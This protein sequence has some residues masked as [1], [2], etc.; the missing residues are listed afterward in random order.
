MNFDAISIGKCYLKVGSAL[1]VYAIE[2][3]SVGKKGASVHH[4]PFHYQRNSINNDV[5]SLSTC[6]RGHVKIKK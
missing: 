4:H 5:L 1:C 3:V 2:M 6:S